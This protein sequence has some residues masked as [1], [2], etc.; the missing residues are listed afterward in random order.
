MPTST[1]IKGKGL[2]LK[3]GGTDYAIDATAISLEADDSTDGLTFSEVTSG[4]RNWKFVVEA[5]QSTDNAS[6]W[7]YLWTNAGST[8]VAFIF[9]PWGNTSAT[10]SQPIFTGTLQ[11]PRKPDFGGTANE[12]FTFSFELP[13]NGE[14]TLS[15]S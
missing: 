7:S 13:V 2:T 5:I 4:A 1:R 15:R 11:V 9:S 6:F 3:I 14:P 12:N 8:S 10:S